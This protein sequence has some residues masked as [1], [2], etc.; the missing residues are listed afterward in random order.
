METT[1]SLNLATYLEPLK[2]FI[3]IREHYGLP[4]PVKK[5]KII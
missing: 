2:P 1:I 3:R 4:R 5:K